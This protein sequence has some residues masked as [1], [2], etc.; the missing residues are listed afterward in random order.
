[1]DRFRLRGLNA[2]SPT[3]WRWGP[4]AGGLVGAMLASAAFA[5]DKAEKMPRDA[6]EAAR[7]QR[8]VPI[9][10]PEQRQSDHDKSAR[11]SANGA[12]ASSSAFENQPDRGLALGFDFAHDPLNAKRPMQTAEEIMK[13]DIAD[14]P[15][16]TATQRRLLENRYDLTPSSI[17]RP[18][19]RAASRLRRSDRPT[20]Q[21]HDLG[22]S[23]PR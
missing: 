17:R 19:C 15:K 20:G 7:T 2:I 4:I 13:Q 5:V 3:P 11:F 6:V 9:T 12:P 8:S 16:V 22:A 23:S 14:K 10:R 1:M 21:G 18:R